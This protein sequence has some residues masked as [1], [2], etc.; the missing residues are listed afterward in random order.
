MCHKH[1]TFMT[2][3]KQEEKKK[4]EHKKTHKI[5]RKSMSSTNKNRLLSFWDSNPRRWFLALQVKL[6]NRSTKSVVV[7]TG[8]SY[9]D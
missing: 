3:R 7:T 6:F 8:L 5:K 4:H 2:K 1:K 9:H